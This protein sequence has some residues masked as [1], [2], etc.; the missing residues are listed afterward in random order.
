MA[1]LIFL[2][3]FKEVAFT[4]IRPIFFNDDDFGV[5]DLPEEEIGDAHFA[6]STDE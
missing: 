4:E 2:D 5:T 3:G 1:A 6:G